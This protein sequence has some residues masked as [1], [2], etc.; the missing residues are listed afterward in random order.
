MVYLENNTELQQ[1]YIPRND[2]NGAIHTGTS[3]SYQEGFEDGQNYQ[4][5]LLTSTAF[6][7][8]GSYSREYGWNQVLVNVPTSGSPSILEEKSVSI[9]ADTT[10][11]L[12]SENCDGMSKVTIDASE[13]GQSQY[14]DGFDDGFTD[15]YSSGSTDEAAKLSA[16]TFTAN[17]AVTVSDGGYSAVTVNLNTASTFNSGYTSGYT[18][19]VEDGKDIQKR[20]MVSSAFTFNGEYQRLNGWSAIT[21]NVNQSGH[22]DQEL[23]DM[24]DSGYTSGYTDGVIS[25]KELLSSSS[26]TENGHYEIENGWDEIDINVDTASTY[27]S[28][29]DDGFESGV[30][31]Q[32]DLLSTSAFTLNGNYINSNGWSAISINVNQ[33]GHTD[34]ELLDMFQSGYTSGFTDGFA[35]GY[36]SGYTDGYSSG[37]SFGFSSGRTYQRSLL[38]TT[39]FTNNG[40]YTNQNGWSSVTVSCDIVGELYC[41]YC[42]DVEFDITGMFRQSESDGKTRF[43]TIEA[44]PIEGDLNMELDGQLLSHEKVFKLFSTTTS[45]ITTFYGIA[46]GT[47]SSTKTEETEVFPNFGSFGIRG[48]YHSDHNTVFWAG[49][50]SN[51]VTVNIGSELPYYYFDDF[52]PYLVKFSGDKFYLLSVNTG[53]GGYCPIF[54]TIDENGVPCIGYYDE[55]YYPTRGKVYPVYRR[56][57]NGE[58][59][60]N[61]FKNIQTA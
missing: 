53:S 11:V 19:G 8:N 54:L 24:Y 44:T 32:Q 35:E 55:K 15:G 42:E 37:Y 40:T 39:A 43:L 36:G 49:D 51:V 6:T 5:S 47:S 34:Q 56:M 60:Y 45:G 1:V 26:F 52:E 22:T 50:T 59:Q 31:H 23:L 27:Q 29:W 46:N 61:I 25:Q 33:S 4:Q 21:I 41:L 57:V 30:T 17:T 2:S 58:Y 12:P 48:G 28:G 16:V 3:G 20:L 9:T 7:A 13:Y 10:V 14:D 38:S 18:E